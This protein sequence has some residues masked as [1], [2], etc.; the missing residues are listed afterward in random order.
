[1]LQCPYIGRR[2]RPITQERKMHKATEK[3]IN[4]INILL[5]KQLANLTYDPSGWGFTAKDVCRSFGVKV[6]RANNETWRVLADALIAGFT[7]HLNGFNLN[8]IN[9]ADA[10]ALIDTL[11]NSRAG[12][13]WLNLS[14]STDDRVAQLNTLVGREIVRASENARG[15]L[16]VYAIK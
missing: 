5:E 7:A 3:Q 1:M 13:E 6:L 11:K 15:E 16:K 10:S 14:D 9:S 8:K 2:E 12:I 4:Y